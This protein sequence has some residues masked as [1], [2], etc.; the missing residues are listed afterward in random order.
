MRQALA[1][2]VTDPALHDAIERAFSEM[3]Q[4]MVNTGNAGGCPQR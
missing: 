3:A 1:E 4:H 2:Q